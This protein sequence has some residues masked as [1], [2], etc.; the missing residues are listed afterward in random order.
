MTDKPLTC[1]SCSVPLRARV[2]NE[3]RELFCAESLTVCN[4]QAANDGAVARDRETAYAELCKKVQA[5]HDADL[6][7]MQKGMA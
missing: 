2:T 7:D 5:E 6:G 3:G 4:S 1:P